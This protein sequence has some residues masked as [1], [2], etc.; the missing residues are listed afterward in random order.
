MTVRIRR[1]RS[2]AALAAALGVLAIAAGLTGSTGLWI[3]AAVAALA[4]VAYAALLV[5]VRH[6]ASEREMALAFARDTS[7]DWAAFERELALEA[8]RFADEAPST[9]PVQLGHRDLGRFL[10]AYALGWVLTPVVLVVRL[11]GGDSAELQRHPV[12]ER[13]V[14]AQQAGR[15]QSLRL[16]AAGVVATAGVTTV[17]GMAVGAFGTTAAYA[18]PAAQTLYTIRVGDTLGSVAARFGTT[19]SALASANRISDPNLILAG[20]QLVIPGAGSGRAVPSAG[21]YTVRS[22]DTLA[23]IADRFGTTVSALASLNHL[24]DPNF[25]Y[26]GEELRIDGSSSSGGGQTTSAPGGDYTVREGDTLG[27]I[28]A[29]FGT[30]VSD[31][32]ALNHLSNP[33]YIYAG[34]VLRVSGTA[35]VVT[36]DAE[37]SNPAHHSRAR[38]GGGGSESTQ[39]ST[40]VR[41]ALQQV[42][43]P[44]A[45]GGASPSTG[46]DCSGL[47]MYAWAAA[48]VDLDH[49]TVSQYDET[50][51]ISESQLEPGDLVFYN[52]G[53]GAQPGHVAMYIGNGQVVSANAPGTNVQTQPLSWDGEIYGYGRV[54]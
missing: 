14:R 49:Y 50:T 38:S 4:G 30:T 39:A 6:L 18:A 7:F 34:E 40:A 54:R 42:G 37:R 24:S 25:I 15:A 9:S 46:F 11:A 17:G 35:P 26:V 1:R 51:R 20:Q 22:G 2:I 23:K 28:A 16:L 5:R 41:V 32:V 53:S 29:R 33:N 10:V 21:T 13:L 12:V 48:G 52:T 3:A 44:Y 45:W 43:V 8:E 31:L 36:T 19:V 47:A 27:S